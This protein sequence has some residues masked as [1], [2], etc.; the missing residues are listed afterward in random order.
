MEPVGYKYLDLTVG[1]SISQ[2][3]GAL[4][5]LRTQAENVVNDEN[6]RRCGGLSRV[7]WLP[8]I[9]HGREG[10]DDLNG[11]NRD[12]TH[13]HFG[14]INIKVFPFIRIT[15]R[16]GGRNRAASLHVLAENAYDFSSLQLYFAMPM[17]CH[18]LILC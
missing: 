5:G 15:L 14:A 1:F 2:D 7:I 11:E 4:L 18:F 10:G 12:V 9:S 6:G 8:S 13:T 17:L 3:V 16:H